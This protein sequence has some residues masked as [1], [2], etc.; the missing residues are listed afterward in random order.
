[1]LLKYA[2]EWKPIHVTNPG[3]MLALNSNQPDRPNIAFYAN[4]FFKILVFKKLLHSNNSR[5]VVDIGAAILKL[6]DE[7][8]VDQ[9]IDAVLLKLQQAGLVD[10]GQE[11]IRLISRKVSSPSDS[12]EAHLPVSG[13]SASEQIV[14]V[15]PNLLHPAP[16]RRR[17]DGKFDVS[18]R[19]LSN[20]T[21]T[22]AKLAKILEISQKSSGRKITEYSASFRTFHYTVAAPILKCFQDHCNSDVDEF[23]RRW[24]AKFSHS[25][26]K[27]K[28]CPGNNLSGDGCGFGIFNL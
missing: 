19:D 13:D 9:K 4:E 12:N 16:K 15:E 24:G 21:D 10:V 17:V 27:K 14:K 20:L 6:E 3:A 28:R 1:M 7:E 2:S 25:D 11:L 8:D 18:D 5:N 22:R 26:W 23:I